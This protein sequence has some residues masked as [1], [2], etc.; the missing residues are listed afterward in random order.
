MSDSRPL[1]SSTTSKTTPPDK[2]FLSAFAALQSTFGLLGTT[3]APVTLKRCD[4]LGWASAL[5]RSIRSRFKAA[6]MSRHNGKK[7]EMAQMTEISVKPTAPPK[8]KVRRVAPI[9]SRCKYF[10]ND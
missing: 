5:R 10:A 2:D 7:P 1:L 3:P 9:M 8:M 6:L 4:S